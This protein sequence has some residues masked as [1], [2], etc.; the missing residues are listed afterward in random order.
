[1]RAR[2]ASS[3]GSPLLLVGAALSLLAALLHLATIAGGPEWYRF[4]GAGE[5]MAQS[6]ARGEWRPAL[7]TLAIAAILGIWAL[8][9]LSGAGRT[10]RL[11]LLRTVLVA[12]SAVYLARGLILVPMLVLKPSLVDG[13][14]LWS[15][16]IVLA[17]GL[18][19]AIGTALAWRALAPPVRREM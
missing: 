2:I 17:Y 11:P 8:Y 14:T 1:M 16:L 7:I 5:D 19:Y 12:I 6:A 13:F 15:S 18:A 9:A 10:R 3:A 4:F